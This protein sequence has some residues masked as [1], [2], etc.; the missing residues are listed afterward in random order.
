MV[1]KGRDSA[2]PV[3]RKALDALRRY[4]NRSDVTAF[5][6]LLVDLH[7]H[8]PGKR[9]A[10]DFRAMRAAVFDS[11]FIPRLRAARRAL[12]AV[13]LVRLVGKNRAGSVHPAFSLGR[14]HRVGGRRQGISQLGSD[15]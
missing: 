1:F 5:Y 13:G 7:R 15:A 6:V 9:F 10:L 14:P 8:S 3:D 2:F 4:D 12:Q 11:L